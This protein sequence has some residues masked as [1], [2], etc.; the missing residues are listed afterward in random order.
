MKPLKLIFAV[1]VLGISLGIV[2]SYLTTQSPQA[3][4]QKTSTVDSLK[5]LPELNYPDLQGNRRSASEWQGKIVILNFWA[6]WC[7]PC[8]K[9]IPH[10]IEVQTAHK[11]TT[12]FIGVAVDDKE[13]V[14]EFADIMG[15]NYPTLLGDMDAIGISKQL[16]NSFSGLPFTAIFDQNGQL[17]HYQIGEIT[18]EELETKISQLL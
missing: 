14:A 1:A 18:R 3:E 11:D 10:F 17:V 7:P 4:P 9:E 8:R 12:Q 2:S 15:I 16:G 5:T 6:T 13:A